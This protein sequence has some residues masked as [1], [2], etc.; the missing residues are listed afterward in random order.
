MSGSFKKYRGNLLNVKCSDFVADFKR[1][2]PDPNDRL[3]LINKVDIAE[4]HKNRQLLELKTDDDIFV[5]QVEFMDIDDIQIEPVSKRFYPYGTVAA[6]TI[7]WVGPPQQSDKELFAEDRLCRYLDDEVC[8]REDG[9]ECVCEPVL[10]GRRGEMLYD[11]DRRLINRIETQFGRE[12]FIKNNAADAGLNLFIFFK[13]TDDNFITQVDDTE[14]V[15]KLGILIT[16]EYLGIV[17]ATWSHGGQVI[18]A[19]NHVQGRGD[20]RFTAAGE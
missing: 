4:M 14:L 12:H 18:A 3:A 19:K 9:V 10:R 5:A 6:Q 1:L 2:H 8:G 11:V 13:V 16:A 15:A 7:G 20:G 17:A